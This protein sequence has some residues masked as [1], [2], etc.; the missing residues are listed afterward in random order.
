MATDAA[1]STEQPWTVGRLITWTTDYLGKCG[2]LSP[3]L[4]AEVLLAHV[5]GCERIMLYTAFDEVA[6]DATRTAFR[7]L[8]RRRAE[9]APVAY[10]VGFKEFYSLPFEVNSDVLIPRPETEFLVMTVL[11]YAKQASV[12]R[13][14]EIIDVGCGSGAVAVTIAQRLPDASLTATDISP[15][16]LAVAQR[17]AERHGV[18]DRITFIES[19]LFD[20]V[21]DGSVFDVVASNPPYVSADEMTQLPKDVAEHE[22]HLALAGG[23]TG[24]ELTWRL[25]EQAVPRLHSGGIL[26]VETS[27]MLA[28]QLRTRF[29][30]SAELE[31]AEVT[32]DL[33]GLGRVVVARKK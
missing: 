33:G 5:R 25:L 32:Q 6:D 18:S 26:A 30:E 24:A 16:A 12:G 22:P 17:N 27:P 13:P 2:S 9:G 20:Q 11:D 21:P 3:R 31:T 15:Q 19:D 1:N 4:D 10:L 14:L 28:P 7:E 23:E 8:V 29:S